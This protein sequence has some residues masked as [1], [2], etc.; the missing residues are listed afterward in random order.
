MSCARRPICGL[1][2]A[3]SRLPG[4]TAQPTSQGRGRGGGSGRPRLYRLLRASKRS[5]VAPKR[6]KPAGSRPPRASSRR[7]R[8]GSACTARVDV[9]HRPRARRFAYPRHRHGEKLGDLIGGERRSLTSPARL[10]FDASATG[11]SR[12]HDESST[13][14]VR[15]L[16]RYVQVHE[17]RVRVDTSSVKSLPPCPNCSG[18]Q[19]WEAMSGGDSS[20]DP[21]PDSSS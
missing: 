8:G 17:L 6:D 13:H 11:Y 7:R 4:S 5:S 14:R 21:Y 1:R 3:S 19:Q 9:R 12:R 15:C 16:G 10:R 2:S 18:P 20:D